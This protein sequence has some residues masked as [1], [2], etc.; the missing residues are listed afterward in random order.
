MTEPERV[1]RRRALAKLLHHPSI[2]PNEVRLL[3]GLAWQEGEVTE[4]QRAWLGRIE[5]RVG[6]S[7]EWL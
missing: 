2:K 7:D 3:W 1:E 5:Q 6:G 4:S